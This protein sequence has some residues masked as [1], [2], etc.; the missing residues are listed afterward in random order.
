MNKT[1]G[2]RMGMKLLTI[3]DVCN[4]YQVSRATVDRWRKM[5]LPHNKIGRGI[6]FEEDALKKWISEN[7][8]K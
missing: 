3:Q 7:L 5:G 8:G 2:W 1:K 6:R 4:I